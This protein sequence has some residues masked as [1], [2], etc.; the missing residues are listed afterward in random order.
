MMKVGILTIGQSPRVDVT[1]A[2]SRILGNEV[3][4]IEQGGLDRLSEDNLLSIKP[5]EDETVYISK[6]RNGKSV[7]IGKTKLLPLL[8][9][10]L[11]DLEQKVD[12]V[13]MLCTGD[14]PTLKTTKPILFPD[15]LLSN[16][17]EAVLKK[18]ETLG[19]IIPLEEQR[20]T[21]IEKWKEITPTIEVEV[22]SP[23]DATSDVEGAAKRLKE[24]GATT[25][26]LDCMGYNEQHKNQAKKSGLPIILSSY[27][28]ARI[29]QEW[30]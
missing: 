6:L 13:I 3:E 23:Y 1:P 28:T 8:Q 16:I 15:K 2:I 11:I 9:E 19:I 22:A 21:L 24:K 4:V 25:I 5:S 27:M 12:I 18:N 26:V 10:E 14:F 20:L 30:I 29:A 17:L 7:K